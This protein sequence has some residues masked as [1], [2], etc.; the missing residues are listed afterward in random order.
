[1]VDS[2]TTLPVMFRCIPV[3]LLGLLLFCLGPALA[4]EFPVP[5]IGNNAPVSS[6]EQPS[7]RALIELADESL[8]AGLSSTALKFYTEVFNTTGLT[9]SEKERS[10]LGIAAAQIERGRVAEAKSALKGLPESSRQALMSGIVA[11]LEGDINLAQSLGDKVEAQ[12]LPSQEIAWVHVLRGLIAESKGDTV[13]SNTH[14]ADATKSA[15]SEEHRQ[16]IEMLSYRANIIGGK[17]DDAVIATLR[18]RAA[19]AKDSPLAFAVARNLAIAL[20]RLDRKADAVSALKS[21][22]P[23]NE[24][25]QGESD[26]L[27]GLILG[28]DTAEGRKLLQSA[29]KNPSDTSLRLTAIRALVASAAEAKPSES[30]SIANEVYD[31]FMKQRSGQLSYECPRDPAVLDAIHLARAQLMLIAGNHEKAKQ[32]ANDLIKDVPASP[33]AREATRTL[34]LVAWNEGAY[35]LTSSYL[36]TLAEGKTGIGRDVLKTV[37]A[38]CLFLAG[39]YTLAEK[40]YATI[41]NETLG[42]DLAASAFHQRVLCLLQSPDDSKVW[43]QAAGVIEQAQS[44]SKISP[45]RLWIATWC[46]IEDI[47]KST[48]PEAASQFLQRLEPLV[49]KTTTDFALRFDWQRAL[50][51]L[52]MHDNITAS[53]LA[54]DIARRLDDLPTDAS[55]ELKSSAPALRG[56][57]A[58]LKARTALGNNSATG[59]KDLESIRKNFAKTPAAAASL[60]VEGRYLASSGRHA[61]AQTRFLELA[62]DF[63]SPDTS[64]NEFAELGLYEAAEESAQQAAS[65]GEEKLKG[66]VELLEQFAESFPKSPLLFQSN[67]RR[68]ELLRTMGDFNR[69]LLVLNNLIRENPTHP[70]RSQAEMARADSLFGLA[71]LR[72]DRTGQLERQKIAIAAAAYESVSIA[73]ARDPDTSVEAQYKLATT[74]IERAKAESKPDAQS[75]RNE[76]RLILVKIIAQ[77]R[78]ANA[79]DN[80]NFGTAGRNWI[81]RSIL[82][83]G[84]FYEEEGDPA[85]AIA[86]YRLIPELNRNLAPHEIR[87]P[88]QA[89]A[90]SKLAT[91]NATLNKASIR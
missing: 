58:L 61:E 13:A 53:K 37:S 91:L 9:A 76:A 51:A 46:L 30:K 23:L 27:C 79:G 63:K 65:E 56:H 55:A 11:L 7:Q 5:V 26:L 22:E 19:S 16:R 15:V 73:W 6:S 87:L 2:P 57:I 47:R 8:A 24:I 54:D 18:E 86:V 67:L 43:S 85:E 41:Q 42:S 21:V 71:E 89:A 35:R 28:I 81:S 68:A 20:A 82:L 70:Y 78:N 40:A 4:Q 48:Q 10:A 84:S 33:L 69:S 44:N 74:L 17:S 50:L 90:E 72:R 60:L 3:T 45:N 83:L 14:F 38:D 77:I 64:L 25:R 52:T 39:D 12:K 31:F 80:F 32:A 36:E 59:L 1:M 49:T 75:T 29:A 66:A 88:G 62:H 34:A